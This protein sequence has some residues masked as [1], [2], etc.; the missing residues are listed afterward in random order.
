MVL[1]NFNPD[2][3]VPSNGAGFPGTTALHLPDDASGKQ[4]AMA[5]RPA[6]QALGR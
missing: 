4:L 1:V 2:R 3:P 5:G 6:S